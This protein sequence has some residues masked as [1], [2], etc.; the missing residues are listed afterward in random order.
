[1]VEEAAELL[2][3]A[4]DE[5]I[6]QAAQGDVVH[7]DDTGTRCYV[8]RANRWTSAR[9][10]LPAAS[11][12]PAWVGRLRCTSPDD[13]HAGENRAQH[14]GPPI[15]MCDALSRKCVA[16][17]I[18]KLYD[19]IRACAVTTV[20]FSCGPPYNACEEAFILARLY[21]EHVY[22]TSA[23]IRRALHS[24]PTHNKLLT[25]QPENVEQLVLRGEGP[26]KLDNG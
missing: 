11:C 4:R 24:N 17:S 7:N 21:S 10:C 26:P 2:K 8:S 23:A 15:P 12:P 22:F 18:P 1:V 6:R 9:V 16:S 3:P 5:L 25:V 19:G 20:P 14:A 13:Q